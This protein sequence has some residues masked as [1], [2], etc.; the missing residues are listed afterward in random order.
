MLPSTPPDPFGPFRIVGKLGAGGMGD[1][2]LAHDT[3]LGRAVALKIPRF[4]PA[5]DAQ[6]ISRFHREARI[7]AQLPAHPHLCPVYEA[8]RSEGV[9]YL[10]MAYIE[11]APL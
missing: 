2:Y 10:S 3:R 4:D 1:V 9:D 11:G 7:A 5:T 6:M 8:G